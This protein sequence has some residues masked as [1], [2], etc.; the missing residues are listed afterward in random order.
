MLT[1][2]AAV[3]TLQLA[4]IQL[5]E[6]AGLAEVPLERLL[7]TMHGPTFRV[8]ISRLSED[9]AHI[10]TWLGGYS[11]DP[12]NLSTFGHPVPLP[13]DGPVQ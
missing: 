10:E 1:T 9:G 6:S 7:I 13:S 5:I 8:D 12:R 2:R 11:I 3:A 4:M